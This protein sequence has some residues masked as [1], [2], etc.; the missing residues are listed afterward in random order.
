MSVVD[1]VVHGVGVCDW[2]K[3]DIPFAC[4]SGD[5]MIRE[6]GEVGEFVGMGSYLFLLRLLQLSYLISEALIAL[7]S[8]FPVDSL[9]DEEIN[10]KVVS[11]VGGIE[12]FDYVLAR[13]HIITKWR[14]NV[15]HWITKDMFVDVI[16]QHCIAF[17]LFS[18]IFVG[19]ERER[20]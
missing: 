8:G 1:A 3:S 17:I 6:R 16:P 19:F 13:N 11:V 5:G 12:Q 7:T 10:A 15:S 2:R 14:E 18:L 20:D 4:R 9:T